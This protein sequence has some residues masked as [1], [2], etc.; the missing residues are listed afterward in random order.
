MRIAIGSDHHGLA[1]KAALT[2]ALEAGG[3]MVLDLGTFTA[4]PVDYPDYA[5]VVGQAVLRHFVD[6]AVL[7]CGSGMGAAVAANKLRGVRAVAVADVAGA[8]ESREQLD[9]NVL[10]LSANA[11]DE[12]AAAEVTLAWIGAGF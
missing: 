6:A 8:L 5:R 9:A 11:L 3:H 1:R 7:V 10:C 12:G 4:D 2:A